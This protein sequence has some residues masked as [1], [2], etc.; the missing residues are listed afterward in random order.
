MTK[1][2]KKYRHLILR[3]QI[4][5]IQSDYGDNGSGDGDNGESTSLS[6]RYKLPSAINVHRISYV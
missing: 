3:C 1:N 4:T 6:F 5:V 2:G